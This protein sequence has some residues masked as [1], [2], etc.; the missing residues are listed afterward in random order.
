MHVH[1]RACVFARAHAVILS[2]RVGVQ[3]QVEASDRRTWKSTAD[4]A[5]WRR[6]NSA[7]N[8]TTTRHAALDLCIVA[9]DPPGLAE[10]DE[11]SP[12]Q[13]PD[14]EVHRPSPTACLAH[15][16]RWLY[17]PESVSRTRAFTTL[18]RYDAVMR[19]LLPHHSS[20]AGTDSHTV[21][22]GGSNCAAIPS[23]GTC[24]TALRLLCLT[25]PHTPDSSSQPPSVIRVHTEPYSPPVATSHIDTDG[26][27]ERVAIA[28]PNTPSDACADADANTDAD[29]DPSRSSAHRW[30]YE[31]AN[32]NPPPNTSPI[33][34]S[35]LRSVLPPLHHAITASV[36]RSVGLADAAACRG[37]L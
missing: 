7:T 20:W 2:A 37:G 36:G 14:M 12:W 15:G 29:T 19:W 21:H 35:D 28:A 17:R 34:P 13:A 22:C 3:V 25:H 18:Q 4:G 16:H 9:A 8:R 30:P 24:F 23:I 5:W 33:G 26:I 27:A 32:T 11:A 31:H 1:A 6:T 10:C